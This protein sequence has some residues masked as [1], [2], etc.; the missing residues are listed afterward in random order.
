MCKY[1]MSM[2]A[3]EL[4]EKYPFVYDQIDQEK[5]RYREQPRL[6]IEDY[7]ND[8]FEEEETTEQYEIDY[9]VKENYI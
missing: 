1:V 9:E 5:E 2:D 4:E 7:Y 8:N 6:Y 3:K